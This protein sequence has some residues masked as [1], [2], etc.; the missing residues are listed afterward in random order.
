MRTRDFIFAALGIMIF[1]LA[2]ADL[3][4]YRLDRSTMTIVWPSNTP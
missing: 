1:A 2:I 3:L 4:G